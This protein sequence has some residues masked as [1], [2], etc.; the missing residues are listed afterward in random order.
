MQI[1]AIGN[2]K[3]FQPKQMGAVGNAVN[4]SLAASLME[5]VGVLKFSF[6]KGCRSGLGSVR[7][8]PLEVA[9]SGG[10]IM[11]AD[12][13]SST[14]WLTLAIPAIICSTSSN[15]MPAGTTAFLAKGRSSSTVLSTTRGESSHQATTAMGITIT[16]AVPISKYFGRIIFSSISQGFSQTSGCSCWAGNPS[17]FTPRHDLQWIVSS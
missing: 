15:V 5:L 7:V 8:A 9:A 2:L 1:R 6:S 13:A 17:R 14:S 16:A 4:D 10:D 3:V 12:I 11:S